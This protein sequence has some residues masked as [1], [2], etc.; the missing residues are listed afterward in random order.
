MSKL[1]K[2]HRF[3][4]SKTVAAGVLGFLLSIFTTEILY[5]VP[6]GNEIIFAEILLIPIIILL[7]YVL[8]LFNEARQAWWEWKRFRTPIKL[9][10]LS[11]YVDYLKKGT[12]CKPMFSM[13]GGWSE[14]FKKIKVNEKNL[15]EVEDLFWSNIS[16]KYAV[17]MNPFGEIYL[18]EDRRNFTTYEKIKD[19]V[20]NG[21]VFC[22]T[23]GFPFYYHWDPITNLPVV[24]TPKTRV[25]TN[26]G[27][28]DIALFF[29]SLVTKDF[30]VIITNFPEQPT[31]SDVYQEN[32]PDIEFF[33]ELSNVGGTKKVFEFRSLSEETRGFHISFINC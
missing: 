1:E 13:D 32:K 6:Q 15:F 19:F 26:A 8:G 17:I 28:A 31:Q 23:G 16:Q 3:I 33:G 14:Y 22:C 27:F 5:A 7:L 10:V 4:V 25:T 30:G 24:T 29:D 21:G 20:A 2:A 18:E 12:E 11:G 9:G